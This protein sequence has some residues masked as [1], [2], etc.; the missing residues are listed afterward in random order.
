M[1]S[2]KLFSLLL[3]VGLFVFACK[4]AK[5]TDAEVTEAEGTEQPMAAVTAETLESTKNAFQTS[6]NSAKSLTDNRLAEV[7]ASLAN[8]TGEAKAELETKVQ[9]LTQLQADLN[10]A[11]QKIADATVETWS[12]VYGEVNQVMEQ[13]KK[14]LTAD[15]DASKQ[16]ISN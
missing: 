14:A 11:S 4:E 8:A 16:T 3:A 9:Q 13:A 6:I 1:K 5:T 2:I 12:G 10:A 15:M 7:Q